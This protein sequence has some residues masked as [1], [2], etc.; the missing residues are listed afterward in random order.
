MVTFRGLRVGLIVGSI[1]PLLAFVEAAHAEV[2]T[3]TITSDVVDAGDGR[4]SLREAVIAANSTPAGDT[5]R[6]PA[7]VYP[8]LLGGPART[9]RR[10]A[11]S[12]SVPG[13]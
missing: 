2:I 9:W 8:I 11:T 1:V 10:R 7:G 6:V 5:I 12:T 3:V 13:T 4:L